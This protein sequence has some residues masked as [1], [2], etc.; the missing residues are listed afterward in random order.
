[1]RS[2]LIF[3][4]WGLIFID[5]ASPLEKKNDTLFQTDIFEAFTALSEYPKNITRNYTFEL[6]RVDLAPDGVV[7]PV[8]AVNGQYPGPMIRAN[9]GDKFNITVK[10]HFGD[11]TAIHWHGID[12]KGTN[13]FDG[14]P[15]TTQCPIP[16]GVNF[17]YIFN[18]N[19][20]GTY[21]YHSHF[22]SQLVD[23]TR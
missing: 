10:N 2:K 3:L 15:G 4:F 21:W 20:S 22:F 8:W 11:P 12:Q 7:R 6:M 14:V 18:L 19:Q 16:N 23:G 17:S 13:W 9:I 1:M 5:V